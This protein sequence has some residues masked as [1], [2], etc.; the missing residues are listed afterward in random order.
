MII[1]IDPGPTNS[2]Y[3]VI[4]DSYN[5]NTQGLK[6]IAKGW[7]PNAE[8]EKLLEKESNPKHSLAIE[9]IQSYGASVGQSVFLTCYWV[10]VFSKAFNVKKNTRLYARPS[11]LSHITGGIRSKGKKQV[12]QSMM[13]RF[14]GTKKGEPLHGITNHIW[15]AVAVVVYH[16]DGALLGAVE[17]GE[18]KT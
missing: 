1:G 14:G 4:D 6:V 8:L 3:V 5:I 18:M 7:V 12:R 16:I 10:G 13:V 2:A 15:D 11:I 9:F 17:W